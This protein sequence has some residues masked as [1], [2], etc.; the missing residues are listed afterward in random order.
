MLGKLVSFWEGL[1]SGAMLNFRGVELI[2][3]SSLQCSSKCLLSSPLLRSP[4]SQHVDF[5]PLGNPSVGN[6]IF[7]VNKNFLWIISKEYLFLGGQ[8]YYV[9][10]SMGLVYHIYLRLVGFYDFY[11]KVNVPYIEGLGSIGPLEMDHC[12]FCPNFCWCTQSGTPSHPGKNQ[13]E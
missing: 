8:Q 6:G 13:S 1:F 12:F 2:G 3:F 4:S 11:V 10:V 7:G 5:E 9:I